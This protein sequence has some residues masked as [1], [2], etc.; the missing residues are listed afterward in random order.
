M[1]LGSVLSLSWPPTLVWLAHYLFLIA[2]AF[3]GLFLSFSN[4]FG[5]LSYYSSSCFLYVFPISLSCLVSWVLWVHCSP[6]F[7]Q[8]WLQTPHGLALECSFVFFVYVFS[9]ST[10]LEVHVVFLFLNPQNLEVAAWGFSC[11]LSF[12]LV[13]Q[14]AWPFLFLFF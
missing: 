8:A 7:P 11:F 2:M 13:T 14:H 3:W 9:S 1:V 6:I 5:L 12:V 4:F 10:M